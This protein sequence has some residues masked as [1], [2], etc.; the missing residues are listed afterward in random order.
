MYQAATEHKCQVVVE[1][2]GAVRIIRVRGRLDWATAGSFRDRMC[3]EWTQGP[4]IIDLG[5]ATGMDSSG[6]GVVLAVAVRAQKRGQLLVIVSLDPIV[7]EVLSS[8]SLG[9]SVPIVGSREAALH[10]LHEPSRLVT[11]T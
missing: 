9:L 3:N 4:M 7:V 11:R 5:D 2:A 10:L 1:H 6:T 8:P